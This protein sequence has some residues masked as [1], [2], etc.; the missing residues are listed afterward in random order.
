MI[1]VGK[2]VQRIRKSEV[3][4]QIAFC[5]DRSPTDKFSELT[6]SIV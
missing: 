5:S 6:F 4:G 3:P 1:F 2:L